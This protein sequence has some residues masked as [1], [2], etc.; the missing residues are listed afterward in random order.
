MFQSPLKTVS[1]KIKPVDSKSSV[2]SLKFER[3]SDFKKFINF[4]KNET[5]EL[6][7]IKLPKTTELE[8][9]SKRGGVLGLLGLGLFGLL[10]SAFGDGDGNDR[11]SIAGGTKSQF[12][13]LDLV[14]IGGVA[15]LRKAKVG[16]LNLQESLRKRRK[17]KFGEKT[18]GEMKAGKKYQTKKG[19]VTVEEK[20]YEKMRT[21]RR[22]IKKDLALQ[23]K[24]LLK[25]SNEIQLKSTL[26]DFEQLEN[27]KRG[28]RISKKYATGFDKS[29]PE[30]INEN[31]AQKLRRIA[32]EI[33]NETDPVRKKM[34]QDQLSDPKNSLSQAEMKQQ[35]GQYTQKDFDEAD[36]LA[37]KEA[38]K[39]K[40]EKELL[41]KYKDQLKTERKKRFKKRYAFR[42]DPKLKMNF[43]LFG[44]NVKFTPKDFLS[45]KFKQ[46]GTAT[47]PARDMFTKTMS[48]IPGS[49]ATFGAGKS[50][51][52]GLGKRYDIITTL[53][54]GYQLVKGFVVG[55][56]ILTA[57]YDLG[58]AIHNMFQPDKAKLMTYITNH[59]DSRLKV[60]K[61]EK[62]QK[63]LGEIQKAK[64]AQALSGGFNPINKASDIVPFAVQKTGQQIMLSSPAF[65]GYRFILDKLYKQ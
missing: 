47:K 11:F 15:N 26:K 32:Q 51:L 18:T 23:Y 30:M 56:N 9:K 63:I 58:V 31:P 27:T 50:I 33:Q 24:E 28:R 60:K 3:P 36:K 54:E 57:Y 16:S 4:I 49:K 29:I 46:F 41:K 14:P 21:K 48:K 39:L 7:K 6:E 2:S 22:V 42:G 61:Q 12:E 35:M 59:Q 25:K 53:F 19:K 65:T 10:G 64:E 8:S 44:K 34:L 5:E 13:K 38:Q 17:Q 1:E 43:D 45:G 37:K 20:K 62:N 40:A 52:K 55:D